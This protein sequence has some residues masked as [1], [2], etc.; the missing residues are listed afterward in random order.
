[1]TIRMRNMLAATLLL[2]A[3]PAFAQSA[4][5][6]P[7]PGA[8]APGIVVNEPWARAS[9]GAARTGAAY[10]TLSNPG[11][12]G[13]RLVA[14]TTPVAGRVELHTHV[15]DGDVMRMRP[16]EAIEIPAG[17]KADLKPGGLHIM[18]LDLKA[19]LKQGET[20]PLTLQFE[21]G[22]AQTVTVAIQAAGAA[23]PA[24]HGGHG[25]HSMAPASDADTIR[26]LMKAA[27]DQPDNPLKVDPLVIRGERAVVG[28]AQGDQGGRALL[29]KADTGKWRLI[30]CSGDALRDAKFLQQTGMSR[31]DATALADAV[32]KAE[33]GLPKATLAQFARFD[34][35]VMMDAEGNHPPGHGPAHAPGGSGHGAH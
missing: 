21:K 20:F 12:D 16:V 15:R 32:K 27:F 14:A 6:S 23:G 24:E 7:A 3:S 10:L 22:R 29:S 11:A 18:L 19:P 2:A 25:G 30:L 31:R 26:G 33:S 35:V 13:D 9:A 34:G 4:T 28:W 8:A 5:H 17:A 1:M